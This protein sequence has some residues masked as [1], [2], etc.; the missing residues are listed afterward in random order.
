MTA[1]P[2]HID[3]HRL[4]DRLNRDQVRALHAVA[5][6]LLHALFP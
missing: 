3:L 2:D 4:V 6:Q 1:P 5:Q